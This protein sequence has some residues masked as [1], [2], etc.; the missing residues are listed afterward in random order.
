MAYKNHVVKTTDA[1]L[2]VEDNVFTVHASSEQDLAPWRHY[3]SKRGSVWENHHLQ[4]NAPFASL[5]GYARVIPEETRRFEYGKMVSVARDM[6]HSF[7][8]EI[9]EIPD[10]LES[11]V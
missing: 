11:I 8:L 3:F 7:K 10:E 1:Y 5:G 2:V 4:T 6:P 9:T